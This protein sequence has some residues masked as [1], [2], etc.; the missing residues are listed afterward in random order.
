M[1]GMIQAL[2]F[3]VRELQCEIDII[4]ESTSKHYSGHQSHNRI[5]VKSYDIY[6]HE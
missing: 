2:L 4:V 5:R 6:R 3:Y 1:L